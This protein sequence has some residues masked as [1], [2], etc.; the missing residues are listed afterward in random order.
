MMF[1]GNGCYKYGCGLLETTIATQVL[2][3][4]LSHRLIWNRFYNGQNK[5]DTNIPLDLQ[6]PRCLIYIVKKL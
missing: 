4:H 5:A 1:K 2:P 6:V 3:G